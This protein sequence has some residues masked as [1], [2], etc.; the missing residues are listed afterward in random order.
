MQ[1]IVIKTNN[2]FIKTSNKSFRQLNINYN[3][4][5]DYNNTILIFI[6]INHDNL[7]NLVIFQNKKKRV[8]LFLR[9]S[10][11]IDFVN[12]FRK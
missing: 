7:V 9:I 6:A 1:I 3:N 11:I 2:I 12:S 8:I 4:L 5:L 10:I